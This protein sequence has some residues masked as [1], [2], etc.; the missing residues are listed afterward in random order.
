[1]S[2]NPTSFANDQ[3]NG[4]VTAD[5]F[6]STGDATS[7]IP[8]LTTGG[9]GNMGAPQL[10][11]AAG[12]TQGA[13]TAITRSFA[14]LTVVTASARGARLPAC[15]TG[16]KV[17]LMSGAVQGC[18]IYPAANDKIGAAATNVAVVLAGNKANLY[19][20][21]DAVTWRVQIGA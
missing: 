14:I 6:T 7:S 9:L 3:G 19:V 18:K 16:R 21:Q 1:M 2:R 5:G 15:V 8:N 13:A 12:A 10:V 4:T 17:L 11:T 20:G